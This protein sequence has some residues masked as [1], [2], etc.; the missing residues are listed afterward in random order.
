MAIWKLRPIPKYSDCVHHGDAL[1]CLGPQIGSVL[2]FVVV[3]DLYDYSL[4]KVI[5]MYHKHRIVLHSILMFL[6]PPNIIRDASITV[7][8]LDGDI[9]VIRYKKKY[10]VSKISY[11]IL[12]LFFVSWSP[13]SDP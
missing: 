8:N 5:L 7:C 3:R 11:C 2:Y 4:C 13:R 6:G 10:A 9:C 1:G 12:L